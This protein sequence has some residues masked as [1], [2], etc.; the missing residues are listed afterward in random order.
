[1]I[2]KNLNK[3]F[4]LNIFIVL[5]IFL[6]DR[7]SKI[8]VIYLSN[9]IYSP[10]IFSSKFLNIELIWNKG[11]AFGLFSSDQSYIYNSIT[12]IIL[13]I[14]IL[15]LFYIK[16]TNGIE[17]HSY[18]MLLGGALGNL[19]D[20]ITYKAVP[21]FIDFHLHDTHW[22]IFNIADIFITLPI[23]MLILLEIFKTKKYN[24][25]I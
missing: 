15:I 5:L 16:N 18:I 24:E 1:M 11:I 8:Y 21:D 20:R 9:K 23:I 22:F 6:I 7:L 25:N 13:T 19:Y 3:N 17:R 12:L 10:K 14:I 4:F 2:F